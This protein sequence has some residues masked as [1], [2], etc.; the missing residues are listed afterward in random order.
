[1]GDNCLLWPI[2]S[3]IGYCNITEVIYDISLLSECFLNEE[4]ESLGDPKLEKNE[5]V[6]DECTTQSCMM[7]H[8]LLEDCKV[9]YC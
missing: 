9:S 4:R 7:V 8:L 1:M 6:Y 5:I 2:R 3:K